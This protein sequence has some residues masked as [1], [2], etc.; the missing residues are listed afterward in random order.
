MIDAHRFF[1]LLT[2]IASYVTPNEEERF[3]ELTDEA[4]EIVRK[5]N[6]QLTTRIASLQKAQVDYAASF[7]AFHNSVV[8]NAEDPLDD[9]ETGYAKARR[10]DFIEARF[11]E[12]EHRLNWE[13]RDSIKAGI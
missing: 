9:F 2:S 5:A 13:I 12:A 1:G 3:T 6:M 7:E 10:S 4:R 11:D 8:D